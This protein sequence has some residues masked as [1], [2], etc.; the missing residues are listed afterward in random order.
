MIHK[1]AFELIEVRS[2]EKGT[3]PMLRFENTSYKPTFTVDAVKAEVVG[4]LK[5]IKGEEG[6]VVRSNFT[7]LSETMM[8]GW[9]E[10]EE[11]RNELNEFYK[12]FVD[13]I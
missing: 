5:K 3:K 1:A 4:L 13:C 8:K 11:S 10:G 7:K 12:K 2:G 6:K 9:D